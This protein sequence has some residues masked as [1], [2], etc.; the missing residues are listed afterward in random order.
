VERDEQGRYA[1]RSVVL[2]AGGSAGWEAGLFDHFQAVVKTMCARLRRGANGSREA[3]SGGSTYTFSIWAGHPFEDEVRGF[4][5]QFPDRLSKLRQDIKNH[6]DQN[7][8]PNHYDRVTV[9][10]GVCVT[11]E[12]Q[13]EPERDENEPDV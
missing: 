8:L 2:D 3:E 10:G 12:E 7:P 5:A 6:N 9:Y 11:S 13:Q 1:C 4:L